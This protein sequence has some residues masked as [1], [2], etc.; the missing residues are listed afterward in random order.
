MA[1]G[2]KNTVPLGQI[3]TGS[4]YVL[5]PNMA[6]QK[7]MG[8]IDQQR[9]M[10]MQADQHNASINRSNY[11]AFNQ[12]LSQIKPSSGM[13]RDDVNELISQHVNEGARLMSQGINPYSPDYTNPDAVKASQEFIQREHLIET[14]QSL[15]QDYAKAKDYAI[16]EY[17][18]NPES[19]DYDEYLNIL[20]FEKNNTIR[21]IIEGRA[22]LPYLKKAFNMGDFVSK[23]VGVPSTTV[24]QY[25]RGEDGVDRK[26]TVKEPDI[27]RLRDNIMNSFQGGQ[28]AN[29]LNRKLREAGI[30]GDVSGIM[31]TTDVE[32]IR[33]RLDEDFRAPAE[34]NQVGHLIA[35]GRIPSLDSPEYEQFLDDSVKE[36]LRAEQV[37]ARVFNQ[38]AR[39]ALAQSDSSYKVEPTFD[40]IKEADRQKAAKQRDQRHY[41]AVTRH[42]ERNQ[43]GSNDDFSYI[44]DSTVPIGNS[45]DKNQGSVTAKGTIN[46]NNTKV[47]MT[48]GGIYNLDT[49]E[50]EEDSP[51][52]SASLINMGEYPFDKKTGRL[53]DD[54]EVKTNKN[55]EYRK[56]IQAKAVSNGIESNVLIPASKAPAALSGKK[57]EIVNEFLRRPATKVNQ[58]K[59]D[60]RQNT[61]KA[62][63]QTLNLF[64]K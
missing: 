45:Y 30:D 35:S 17:N 31:G 8:D 1:D 56:M 23:N 37:A 54:E 62:S 24:E 50:K 14:T 16:K 48:G 46:L 63:E 55:V 3:G 33:Q 57:Q 52:I 4:A 42:N 29:Y 12:R 15:L 41:M 5:G 51:S 59:K 10:R 32:E 40:L 39:T 20:N 2:Y 49:R 18:K 43:S 26:V 7:W 9:N 28:G 36:Q 22:E 44:G 19:F 58:D 25:Q 47:D 38:A 60:D 11:N 13:Y 61:V 53:L 64:K 6:L 34:G 21:D 27:A